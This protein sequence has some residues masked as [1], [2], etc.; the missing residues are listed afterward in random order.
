MSKYKFETFNDWFC[1][2]FQAHLTFLKHSFNLR[3]STKKFFFR[4]YIPSSREKFQEQIVI[5][6]YGKYKKNSTVKCAKSQLF[7]H[8]SILTQIKIK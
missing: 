5:Q 6:F 2:R 3:L 8:I 4:K 7:Q 1:S